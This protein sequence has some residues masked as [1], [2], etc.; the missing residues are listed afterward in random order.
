MLKILLRRYFSKK[1]R[2]IAHKIPGLAISGHHNFA[3]I[4]DSKNLLPNDPFLLL[5]SI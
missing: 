1:K 4:T 2:K 5:E 3:M